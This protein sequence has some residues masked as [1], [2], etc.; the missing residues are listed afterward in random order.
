MFASDKQSIKG[1]Y[2]NDQQA[3]TEVLDRAL[4]GSDDSPWDRYTH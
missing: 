2:Q 4:R 1:V 3:G